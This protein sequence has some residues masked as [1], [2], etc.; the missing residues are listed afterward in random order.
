MIYGLFVIS[1]GFT[2]LYFHLG[3]RKPYYALQGLAQAGAI[4]FFLLDL[5]LGYSIW[6]TFTVL[7]KLSAHIAPY[8]KVSEVIWVP[9]LPGDSARRWMLDTDDS[10][11][12]VRE[13]Y[14]KDENCGDWEVV[15]K[16]LPFLQ[17]RKSKQ[18]LTIGIHKEN[19]GA[20]IHYTL[21]E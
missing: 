10:P 17:L 8:P 16:D 14:L 5:F 21:K 12:L 2:V 13:F 15:S 1:V 20:T 19:K 3:F 6:Q 7:G 9:P 11:E 4:C 18:V